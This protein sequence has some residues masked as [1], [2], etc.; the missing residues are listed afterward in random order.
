VRLE[1]EEEFEQEPT[2]ILDLDARNNDG[3]VD[4]LVTLNPRLPLDI[5]RRIAALV[6][7]ELTVE[8]PQCKGEYL[9]ESL[10]QQGDV[11]FAR[12]GRRSFLEA[13]SIWSLRDLIQRSKRS[14]NE[15]NLQ[16]TQGTP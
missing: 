14:P 16:T 8:Q 2:C 15:Q 9:G 3:D 13:D 10:W 7:E 1:I 5:R 6:V 12:T 11:Y 4:V